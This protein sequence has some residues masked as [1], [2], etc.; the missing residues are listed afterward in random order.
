MSSDE[1]RL[2]HDRYLYGFPT[3]AF[4]VRTVSHLQ[5][6]SIDEI[7]TNPQFF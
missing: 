7:A 4:V 1:N 5:A 6:P 3:V 2:L